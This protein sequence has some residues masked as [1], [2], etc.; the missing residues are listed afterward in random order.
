[1]ETESA[2]VTGEQKVTE[3][4]SE[5]ILK[6]IRPKDMDYD[7][8]KNYRKIMD[9]T[10]QNRLEGRFFFISSNLNKEGKRITK[11]YIKNGNKLSNKR[12]K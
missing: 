12:K 4:Q 9:K 2:K 10:I 1:M 6:G 7:T 11:T 5:L 3:E 8:F